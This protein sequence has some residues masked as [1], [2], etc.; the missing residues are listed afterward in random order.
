MR[1]V[2]SVVAETGGSTLIISPLGSKV[3]APA[4]LL[5]AL[6]HD[7]PVTYVGSIRNELEESASETIDRQ[8]LK[9]VWSEGKIYPKP[10]PNVPMGGRSTP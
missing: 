10:Q 3:M 7:L 2:E 4:A 5:A 9:H 1:C 6:E 8:N